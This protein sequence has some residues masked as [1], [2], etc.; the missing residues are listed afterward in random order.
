MQ[1]QKIKTVLLNRARKDCDHIKGING[2]KLTFEGLHLGAP[3]L[4]Y[5]KPGL[6]FSSCCF[7]PVPNF[8]QRQRGPVVRQVGLAALRNSGKSKNLGKIN[9]LKQ[10]L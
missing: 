2:S 5:K 8:L 3:N 4:W 1:K 9:R 6:D 7:Y 10:I